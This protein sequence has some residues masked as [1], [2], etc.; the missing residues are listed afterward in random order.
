M[1]PDL[2]KVSGIK[3]MSPPTDVNS[4]GG[5]SEWLINVQNFYPILPTLCMNCC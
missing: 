1:K 5:F 4:L 3:N 2:G